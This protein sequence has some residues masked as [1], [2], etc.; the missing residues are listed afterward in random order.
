[1][2][3]TEKER[4]RE[5]ERA[6]NR[7][8]SARSRTTSLT[9]SAGHSP[10]PRRGS[11]QP[12][13]NPNSAPRSRE[14]SR[15]PSPSDSIRS[16]ATEG[17]ENRGQGSPHHHPYRS[18]ASPIPGSSI[19]RPRTQSIQSNGLD[20]HSHTQAQSRRLRHTPSQSSLQSEGSSRPSSPADPTHRRQTGLKDEDEEAIQERE[21]NWG[22]RQQK[23]TNTHIR[24]RAG[25]PNPTASH[26]RV[27]TNLETDPSAPS[28]STLTRPPNGHLKGRPSKLSLPASAEQ[29]LSSRHSVP[30]PEAPEEVERDETSHPMS[31]SPQSKLSNGRAHDKPFR[32]PLRHPRPDSPLVPPS[33]N[34]NGIDVNGAS[35]GSASRFGWQFPRNRPQLPDFEP[36]TS[37]P[38]RSPSPVYRPTSRNPG[39]GAPSHIPVRSPGQVPKVAIQRNGDVRAFAKGHKRATTEFTEANGAVPPK[40]QV[41]VQPEPEPEFTSE[42]ESISANSLRGS[43]FRHH[44]P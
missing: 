16:R 12:R 9:S 42:P 44:F 31:T 8:I 27:R 5:R 3:D 21:R 36:E 20:T 10:S 11:D 40:I 29:H 39:S 15:P 30:P 7:P 25:S 23:W 24:K 18:T 4:Q 13:S 43:L 35:P 1:M 22:A 14:H 26:S 17:E 33:V 34:G 2:K 38:E 6:W 41:Q 28:S 19:L 37:E 32:M